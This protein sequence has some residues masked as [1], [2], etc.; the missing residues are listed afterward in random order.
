MS[1]TIPQGIEVLVKKAA[2]DPTFK[3]ILL[4]RREEAADEI[5]LEL[6]G[7]EAAILRAVPESQLE[8]MIAKT[9]VP[10]EHR[11]AFLGKAA[12]AML[13]VL[14]LGR[15]AGAVEPPEKIMQAPGGVAPDKLP[16][17]QGVRPNPQ[18]PSL[19]VRPDRPAPKT[20]AELEKQVIDVVTREFQ[21][22]KKIVVNR[23]TSL[24]ILGADADDAAKLRKALDKEFGIA[25]PEEDFKKSRTVGQVIDRVDREVNPGEKLVPDPDIKPIRGIRPGRPA[26]A[27]VQP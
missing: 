21:P 7:A 17:M 12:A 14:G 10:Q 8:A 3:E 22:D 11:R 25:L 24:K 20:P 15:S 6:S 19:G 18:P 23:A 9:D 13:A 27:G 16:A 4:E 5:G 1:Q 2:V 26:T